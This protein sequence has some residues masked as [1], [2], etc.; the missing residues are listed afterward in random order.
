MPDTAHGSVDRLRQAGLLAVAVA[1][2]LVACL[3]GCVRADR[4]VLVP[5]ALETPSGAPAPPAQP[6]SQ[7]VATLLAAAR[8]QPEALLARTRLSQSAVLLLSV[9]VA[10]A[11]GLDFTRLLSLRNLAL[12]LMLAVGACFF[13]ILEFFD[14]MADPAYFQLM[15]WVFTAIVALSAALMLL[16]LHGAWRPV[17]SPWTPNLPLRPVAALALV[18]VAA[19]IHAALSRP[20]DDAGFYVNLG[21][22]RLRERGRLPYGDPLLTGSPA[23]AY[24]PVLYAVQVPFQVAL[25]P[26][27][28]NRPPHPGALVPGAPPYLLPPALASQLCTIA[29]HLLG[30]GAL[31]VAAG[32]MAGP[33]VAWAVV[34]LYAGSSAVLGLGGSGDQTVNGMTFVSHIA[35]AAATLL[36][37]A[38]LPWPAVSGVLLVLGVG[39]LFY[40]L[41]LVPAWLG[42]YW[43]DRAA[44][45]RFLAAVVVTAA[46]V[47][48]A[49][50]ALSQPSGGRSLLGTILAET[51]GH[52]EAATT[53]G[54]S[55]FGFW[56][57]RGG[58]RGLLMQP[59]LGGVSIARPVVLAYFALALGSFWL[60]RGGRPDALAL[61]VGALAIG[62][63][64]WKI[65]ATGTYTAWYYP[66]LLL[67]L[68]ARGPRAP[69]PGRPAR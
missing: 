26:A 39:V 52:Q 21:A 15:D 2:L 69:A 7:S 34:A 56:G 51:L 16:A 53:Y 68:F 14:V 24:G 36:A 12:A 22:Q 49:V 31:F 25:A 46:V 18:L 67:G 60:A 29:F 23:A 42:H 1:V 9:V 30:V 10:I 54:S 58:V 48:A 59:L 45:L 65:H 20:P 4:D 27:P 3:A 47:G 11:V 44:R 62:A 32:R 19:D 13:D 5:R 17:A 61:L 63:Q 28:I 33:H 6:A 43:N 35:P 64:A 57:Q 8:S 55:P 38:A 40:P 50:L 41:F 37:F 66:F